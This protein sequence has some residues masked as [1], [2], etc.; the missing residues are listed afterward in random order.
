M[1]G[2][3]P[4]IGSAL[5]AA[6]RRIGAIVAWALVAATVGTVIRV[7]HDKAGFIGKVVTV[8][9]G[10]TW[11]LAT[12][13]IV[14]VLVLEERSM[15]DSFERSTNVFKETW[16]ETIGGTVGIGLAALCAWIS[17]AALSALVGLLAGT[18]AGVVAFI[19][20]AIML[21]VFFHTLEGVYL[22]TLW[23]YATDG[24]V[25]A[26]FSGALLEQAFVSKDGTNHVTLNLHRKQ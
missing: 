15:R 18:P 13:F 8:A 26:G 17:L 11:S 4:T 21:S 1:R 22:A 5:S 12:F 16:G 3:D 10:V 9:L 20:G 25:P 7:I 24:W 2:G 23:R 14:P 6:R 19:A